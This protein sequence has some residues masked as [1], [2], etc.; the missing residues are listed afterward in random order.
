MS[1]KQQ[2]AHRPKMRL[3]LSPSCKFGFREYDSVLVPCRAQQFSHPRFRFRSAPE[4]R[5]SSI[6]KYWDLRHNPVQFFKLQV[7]AVSV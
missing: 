5:S 7:L 3:F 4:Y 2:V 1:W 6:Y